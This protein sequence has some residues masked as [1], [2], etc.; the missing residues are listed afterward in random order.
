MAGQYDFYPS[1][2]ALE[3]GVKRL[4]EIEQEYLSLFTG[5]TVRMEHSFEF[6]YIPQSGELFENVELFEYSSTGVHHE[7]TGEGKVVSML[8]T[9]VNNTKNLGA[10]VSQVAHDSI[11][12]LYYRI[13][14][15]AE[16]E[17][18]DAGK[19]LLKQRFPVIQY[20]TVLTLPVK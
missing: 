4:D 10:L 18:R 6:Y 14:D 15:M 13:P 9:N 3:F 2:P 19:T 8:I 1:G 11:N 5:K 7:I 17:I 12:T 20:G 16:M